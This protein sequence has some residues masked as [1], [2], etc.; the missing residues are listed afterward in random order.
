MQNN[1]KINQKVI[2]IGKYLPHG[3]KKKIA[4]ISGLTQQTVVSFFK[5]G[6]GHQATAV[7]I[8]TAS[9]P[10]FEAANKIKKAKEDLLEA[11]SIL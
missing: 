2:E 9:Q 4:E 11:M 10:Y 5:T 7:K 1:E 6:K 3:S 8:L